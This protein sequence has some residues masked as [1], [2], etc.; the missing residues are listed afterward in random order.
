MR[1]K[2]IKEY[3]RFYETNSYGTL[4]VLELIG[5]RSMRVRFLT[6][7]TERNALIE[8]VKVGKVA[9]TTQPNPLIKPW[10]DCDEDYTNNSGKKLKVL[11]KNG[12]N[13]I[14]QFLDTGYTRQCNY[15]NIK[16]GKVTDPY[17]VS[18]Y[19]VGY[20][21]EF[22]KV[23]YWKQAK[24]LWKNM[25]KRCYSEKDP[26]GYFGRAFVDSRWKCFAN[27]LKDLP[28][29]E[30]FDLWLKGQKENSEKYNLDKD[31]KIQ[32]NKYYSK[33]A[34]QFVTEFENKSAGGVNR[35]INK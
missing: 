34:C 32:G 11:R 23:H 15:Q 17:A 16:A 26:R 1:K 27:F 6:T 20:N 4:E 35:H 5:N 7:G 29:L 8:N 24:Q 28:E 22:E 30:N 31:L 25:M 33:E 19:G 9:D 12:K 2:D 10:E 13:C 21:G 18:V 3:S 14:I